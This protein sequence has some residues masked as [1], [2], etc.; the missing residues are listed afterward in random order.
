MLQKHRQKSLKITLL[1]E[2]L[3]LA[4]NDMEMRCLGRPQATRPGDGRV[5]TRGYIDGS[6]G[7]AELQVLGSV[8]IDSNL[9]CWPPVIRAKRSISASLIQTPG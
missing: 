7:P 4:E 9:H 5:G 8:G 2:A 3:D 6:R 1:R